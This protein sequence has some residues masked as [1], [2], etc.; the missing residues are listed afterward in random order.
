MPAALQLALI[1][2]AQG[3][4]LQTPFANTSGLPKLQFSFKMEKVKIKTD[5]P[6][7]AATAHRGVLGPVHA[8][9]RVKPV[10]VLPV[11]GEHAVGLRPGDAELHPL[12]VGGARHDRHR[13]D[14]GARHRPPLPR[15]HGMPGGLRAPEAVQPHG[16]HT[17]QV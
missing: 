4:L 14:V 15:R 16:A 10:L 13:D 2:P 12:V 11:R 17:Q 5:F 6:L 3:P 7:T 8:A 1:A 9:V